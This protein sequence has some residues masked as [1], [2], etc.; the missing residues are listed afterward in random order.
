M[1][2]RAA[3]SR[4]RPAV[5]FPPELRAAA[6]GDWVAQEYLATPAYPFQCGDEGWASHRLVWGR[7]LFGEELGG[8]FVRILP[9]AQEWVV[10]LGRG[11]QVAVAFTAGGA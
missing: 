3:L 9:V 7:F 11:P 6:A 2:K 5:I 8:L 1:W 4:G 10:N